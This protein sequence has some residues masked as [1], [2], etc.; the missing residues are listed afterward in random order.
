M[1]E[2]LVKYS[3]G[4]SRLHEYK[5][6]IWVQVLVTMS[7]PTSCSTLAAPMPHVSA[8][9]TCTSVSSQ[10]RGAVRA[11][12]EPVTNGWC[13]ARWCDARGLD[14]A[15]ECDDKF[16]RRRRA[17]EA[18][19]DA[20]V[21]AS[22]L[23]KYTGHNPYV[24]PDEAVETFWNT[25][26]RLAAEC[27]VRVAPRYESNVDACLARMSQHDRERVAHALGTADTTRSTI[28]SHVRDRLL[29]PSVAAHTNAD[30]Q[31]CAV[32][33]ATDALPDTLLDALERDVR[34]ARGVRT[35]A[36][37]VD[38][39]ARAHACDI[40]DRNTT[41]HTITVGTV[42]GRRVLLVGRVD[43]RKA[44]GTVVEVKC[45]RRRLF[46]RIVPYENVQ[47]HAYMAMCGTDA[48]LLREQ[49]DG[50]ACE[51]EAAFDDAFW[52]ECKETLFSFLQRVLTPPIVCQPGA[53]QRR[54]TA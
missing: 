29:A 47:L 27:G 17:R 9:L 4:C 11:S 23:A 10:V 46:R 36:A 50:D 12:N 3:S 21:Y 8:L 41:R 7:H 37:I 31:S 18:M 16:F 30:S 6:H 2:I 43:G 22:H 1:R 13:C 34:T 49:H 48:A 51:I 53:R 40:D 25:N 35:E 54:S 52:S 28:A 19:A 38:A 20:V 24:S 26:P 42:L 44:D 39:V 14:N 45:R 15:G 5:L 32:A 33:G